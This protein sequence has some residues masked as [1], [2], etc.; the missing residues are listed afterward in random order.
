MTAIRYHLS[1]AFDRR[2]GLGLERETAN[3]TVN[4]STLHTRTHGS[5][6]MLHTL[7][8]KAIQFGS[9]RNPQRVTIIHTACIMGWIAGNSL[10]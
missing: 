4:V 3:V 8:M 2:E 1:E 7:D 5:R 9:F 10:L 6:L